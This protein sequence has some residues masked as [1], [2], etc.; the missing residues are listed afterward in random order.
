MC[1]WHSYISR[2]TSLIWRS[3]I[4]ILPISMRSW[5]GDV[6]IV[7]SVF[8]HYAG[9]DMGLWF[10]PRDHGNRGSG[11][12]SVTALFIVFLTYSKEQKKDY[13][14]R[15]FSF[16]YMGAK[17]PVLT[18]LFFTLISVVAVWIG[19]VLLGYE[20]PGMRLLMWILLKS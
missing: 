19:V 15:C 16:R 10:C 1:M 11:A 5:K 7:S 8:Y 20:M 3:S 9:M 13:F 2:F 14:T 18:I 17:W 12:P 4:G 6:K